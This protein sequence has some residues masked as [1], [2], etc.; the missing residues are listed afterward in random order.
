MFS[1]LTVRENLMLAAREGPLD[2]ARL[3][4]IFGFF[5][6][7]KKF[8]LSRAGSL[9]GGQKQ[10]VSI[11]RAIV[12][13]RRLLL[14]DE[15]T[16]GLAPA[17]IGG[18]IDCLKEIKRSRRDDPGGR[19]EFPRRARSRRLRAGDGQRPHRPRRTDGRIRRE[20]GAARR[21]CSAFRWIHT[22]DRQSISAPRCRG[23]SAIWLPALTPL[24]VAAIAAP[25]IGSASTFVTLTAAGLAM[26]MMIFTMASGLTLAFGM[27]DVLNFGH[28]AFISLGAYVATLVFAA[29]GELGAGQFAGRSIWRCSRSRSPRRSSSAARSASCSSGW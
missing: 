3:Q 4:W 5:P 8:W 23:P 29:A 10:M 13:P 26:G 21:G 6:A 16:K 27:M 7:L 18:L 28:G 2:E 15:P 11:A 14:I 19:A 17:I 25:F 12:E 22:N 20:R 24:I 1:D 9:S